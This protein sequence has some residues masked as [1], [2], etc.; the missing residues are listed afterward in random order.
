MQVKS[1][2]SIIERV[3]EVLTYQCCF[4]GEHIGAYSVPFRI[5]VY[6]KSMCLCLG[7]KAAPGRGS[8][9]NLA[10]RP[11]ENHRLIVHEYSGLE[12]G[13][14][15]GLRTV[16]DFITNRADQKRAPAER[17]HAIW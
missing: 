11:E 1:V 12:P 13:D 4:Q 2:L 10:F 14:A 7:N 8:D 9:I 15:F 5:P 17:L 16:R 3:R 6:S